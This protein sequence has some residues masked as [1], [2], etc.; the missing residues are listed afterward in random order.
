M[1]ALSSLA[2]VGLNF[3]LAERSARRQSG[4]ANA[5]RDRQI[6]EIQTRDAEARREEEA[7]LR[8]SLAS[9]RA[10]AGAA[11]VGGRGGSSE[12]V[13]RG[14]IEE[15]EAGLA[16]G[17]S[18]SAQRI[19]NIRSSASAARRRNLLDLVGGA[20]QSGIRSLG[21]SVGRRGSLL[22]L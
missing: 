22:D 1:G 13:L 20:T 5:D 16:A 8:R 2:T 11:G 4:A 17:E 21:R 19:G 14:L 18:L 10:R 7:R 12:A 3:A 6:A 15:S 9:Q